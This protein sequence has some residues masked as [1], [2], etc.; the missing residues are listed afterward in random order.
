[1]AKGKKNLLHF[2]C[3]NVCDCPSKYEKK[4]L[5]LLVRKFHF[6]TFFFQLFYKNLSEK[7]PFFLSFFPPAFFPS[8]FSMTDGVGLMADRMIASILPQTKKKRTPFL[9]DDSRSI[10]EQLPLSLYLQDSF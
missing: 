1:M 4:G 10:N 2:F 8:L 6:S 5:N 3:I 9:E 7:S